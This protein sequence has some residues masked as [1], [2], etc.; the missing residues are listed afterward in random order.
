MSLSSSVIPVVLVALVASAAVA[1]PGT[2]PGRERKARQFTLRAEEPPVLHPLRV[3]AREVT[4]V[5][6]DAPIVP[7][8]VDRAALAPFF[9]R[10]GVYADALVLKASVD[11]PAG[12]GPV[13]TVRFAGEGAPSQVGFVLT[14]VDAEVDSQVEVF[15]HGRTA[16]ELGKELADLRARCAVTEAGFATLR[17]QCA[18]S[19]LGGAVLTGAISPKGVALGHLPRP[20]ESL[21][22]RAV[23]PHVLYRSGDTFALATTLINSDDSRSWAPGVGRVT[24]QTLDGSALPAREYPLLVREKQL[25]PGTRAPVVMEWYIPPEVPPGTTFILELLDATGK[26]GVRWEQ[27]TP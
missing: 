25:E 13:I 15:R 7:D 2:P 22:L 12:Q 3:A 10:V 23:S 14:T 16:Q 5:T 1:Q 26:R 19:G 11:L 20:I 9:S 24:P 18:L 6:F 27:V 17:A 4:T 21:G 8:S